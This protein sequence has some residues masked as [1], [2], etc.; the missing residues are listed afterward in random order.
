MQQCDG[1]WRIEPRGCNVSSGGLGVKDEN[2][3]SL[4]IAGALTGEPVSNDSVIQDI[5]LL[6]RV[7]TAITLT[8]AIRPL[9]S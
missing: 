1:S 3:H 9:K 4:V 6:T 2:A 7:E 8:A 5:R